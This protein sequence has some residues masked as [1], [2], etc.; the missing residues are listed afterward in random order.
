ME[1]FSHQSTT[2]TCFKRLEW[3][4]RSSPFPKMIQQ[5]CS[6]AN[7]KTKTRPTLARQSLIKWANTELMATISL[8][9]YKE[10][11]GETFR[12]WTGSGKWWKSV[13]RTS[14]ARLPITTLTVSTTTNSSNAE[15]YCSSMVSKRSSRTRR[16]SRVIPNWTWKIR[17]KDKEEWQK[18]RECSMPGRS[19]TI[20]RKRQCQR[21]TVT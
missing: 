17:N 13:N 4:P 20:I 7:S 18:S 12:K 2:E 3:T 15:S 14:W 8:S 5:T 10:T 9:R 21:I 19:I 16:S 11:A 6:C 1:E